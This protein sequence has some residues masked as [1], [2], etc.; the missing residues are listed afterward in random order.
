MVSQSALQDS[1]SK[2]KKIS[3]QEH[4]FLVGDITFVHGDGVHLLF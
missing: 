4:S 1:S 3:I 2:T